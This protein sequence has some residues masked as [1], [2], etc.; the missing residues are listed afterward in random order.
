MTTA[1]DSDFYS[2]ELLL[3]SGG[4]DLLHRVRAF[5]EKEVEPVINKYWTREEFP[6]ELVPGI[7]QLG[8]AGLA[9]T[10]LL[11]TSC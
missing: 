1:P 5:M 7:G 8:V 2:L 3:D 11:Y 6:H 10:C 4:R 9:Y